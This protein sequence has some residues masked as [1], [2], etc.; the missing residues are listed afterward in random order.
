[1]FK[2]SLYTEGSK[3]LGSPPLLFSGIFSPQ[4]RS[5]AKAVAQAVTGVWVSV[6]TQLSETVR[7]PLLN[8]WTYQSKKLGGL[9]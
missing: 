1:M 5:I 7:D 3:N 2:K 6:T 4:L 9:K 8:G